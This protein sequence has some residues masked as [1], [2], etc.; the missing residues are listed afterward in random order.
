MASAKGKQHSSPMTPPRFFK[1]ADNFGTWLEKNH[2][3]A[4]EL[5]VGYYK[6][7]S[8]LPSLTWPQSVDEA[9]RFGWIDG[10]RKTIDDTSYMIRFTPR[11]ATS[12]WSNVNIAKVAALIA[13]DRMAAAGL[14]AY[15]RR[16]AERSGIYSFEREAAQFDAEQEHVFRKERKAWEFFQAQPKG[17]KQV[18]TNYVTSAKRPETRA[19]RLADLIACSANGERIRQVLSPAKKR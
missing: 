13:Q 2:A 18:T 6:K 3:T 10:V 8:G 5:W 19:R 9:L 4:T 12:I 7:D 15:T 1:T 14:A 17:Y 16:T 11:K